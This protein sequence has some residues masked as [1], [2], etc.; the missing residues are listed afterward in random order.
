MWHDGT[1]SPAMSVEWGYSDATTDSTFYSSASLSGWVQ[2]DL[3][4]MMNPAK[5]LN[6][7][8]VWGY[9]GGGAQPD[10]TRYDSFEFCL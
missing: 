2:I 1:D 7:I 9:A 4:S 8:R 3:L 6:R 10:I 5:S